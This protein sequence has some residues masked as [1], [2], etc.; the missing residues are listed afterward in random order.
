MR[1]YVY[2]L[3][4]LMMTG[5]SKQVIV[6][7]KQKDAEIAT[8]ESLSLLM[9]VNKSPKVV[10]RVPE[11]YKIS[12]PSPSNTNKRKGEYA[13]SANQ[14]KEVIYDNDLLYNTVEKQLFS[15][16]ELMDRKRFAEVLSKADNADYSKLNELTNTDLILEWASLDKQVPYIT[17]YCF[18]VTKQ[19]KEKPI[20]L[21]VRFRRYGASIEFNLFQVKTNERVAQFKFYYTPCVS[22]CRYIYKAGRLTPLVKHAQ[23]GQYEIPD[24]AELEKF[25]SEATR[26]LVDIIR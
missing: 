26:Q 1:I 13:K 5:C 11:S 23:L 3:V 21:P 15:N 6:R 22:G 16:F 18:V 8:K 10:L 4:A 24:Q 17:E 19:G 14:P 2:F 20:H 25:T 12:T 7:F 9:L